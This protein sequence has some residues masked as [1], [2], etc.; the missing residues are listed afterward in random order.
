MTSSVWGRHTD[1]SFYDNIS[2]LFLFL[3]TPV[4]VFYFINTALYHNYNL[5]NFTL[6][7]YTDVDK[8]Y[9]AGKVIC[10]WLA[11]QVYLALIP[12]IIHYVLPNYKGGIQHGSLS[13]GG[14][15][16]KYNINGLQAW[17][18]SI[19]LFISAV[20]FDLISATYIYDSWDSI[21][22]V[23]ASMAYILTFVAYLKAHFKPTNHRDC[24]F[25]N[26]KFYNYFM[27][28][29]LNPRICNL[30]WKLFFNGRPGIIGW[31]IIN[32]SFAAV[33][34]KDHGYIS[35]S[36]VLLNFLQTLYIGYFF[37]R[38]AWYLKTLDISHDHFGWMFAF[39]DL[40]WLPAMYTL[41]GLYLVVNPIDL[42]IT[43]FMCVLL[44]GCYGFYI[45][46]CSNNEKDNF[47]SNM[48]TDKSVKIISCK[49]ITSDGLEHKSS[50]LV[51]G[52]WGTC[53]HI[54]YT[55]DILLSLAYSLS[56]GTDNIYP[57]FYVIYLTILLV[58]R[59]IRD[60]AKCRN[61]YGDAW[62]TYCKRVPYLF[63]PYII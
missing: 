16:Y 35:N 15:I 18:I 12:D 51:S 57:Y 48:H 45:F 33:Q 37:Y 26:S 30:D 59:S 10:S 24:K 34:Y 62:D 41:Q 40:V 19:L 25:T 36:M 29:E 3:T 7:L 13:P 38:E 23:L 11:L 54:N 2:C 1:V 21:L 14:Y 6:Y 43:Y 28:I 39:G 56:C 5:L 53:R 52:W 32:I 4:I 17:I 42:S 22:L 9:T 20:Y 60:D 63:I 55:G 47:R 61:K 58:H 27:G 50:L 44:L 46:L 8:L 49:Y 31:S